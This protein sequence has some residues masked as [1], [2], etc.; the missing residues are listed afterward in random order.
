M[1][2]LL[3]VDFDTQA[4]LENKIYDLLSKADN[5]ETFFIKASE[6]RVA[7]DFNELGILRKVVRQFS[8]KFNPS[9]IIYLVDSIDAE[10][11]TPLKS[12][13]N[14]TF[15]EK[16]MV[17]EIVN[18]FG[19]IFP[20]YNFIQTEKVVNGIGRID[21]FADQNGTP[22][23]IEVKKGSKNPTQQLLAYATDFV[24]PILIGITEKD[25]Q[26]SCKKEGVNYY[27]LD[28]L[29]GGVENWIV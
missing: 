24:N 5:F 17:S 20:K 10:R 29:K 23:I 7:F 11:A 8:N 22:V 21:I 16:E 28:Q 15:R 4:E 18:N 9:A 1:N 13:E 14:I 12:F 6:L 2:E 19:K 25:I 27:T 26:E 3:K